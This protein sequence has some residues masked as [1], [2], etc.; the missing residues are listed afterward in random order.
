[1]P[2]R[3][4]HRLDP[5]S[6]FV[7]GA[8]AGIYAIAWLLRG[9]PLWAD[10]LYAG[11][12]ALCFVLYAIDKSAAV[13]GRDRLPES[14]LLWPGLAGGWPGAIVAQQLLRHKT[15]KRSFRIRFWLSVLAN[16]ALFAWLAVPML[17]RHGR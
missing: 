10:V 13:D 7:L 6:I 17:F 14:L 15:A 8:F 9:V 2:A 12:S 16:I 1:M 5:A 3:T 11:A 4:S